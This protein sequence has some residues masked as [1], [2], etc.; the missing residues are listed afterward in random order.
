M[1]APVEAVPESIR[2]AQAADVDAALPAAAAGA[3]I[4]LPLAIGAGEE[5]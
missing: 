5:Q 3:A 2:A 1:H 4:G